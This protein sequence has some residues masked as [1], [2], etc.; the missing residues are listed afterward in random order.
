M[1]AAHVYA[2]IYEGLALRGAGSRRYVAVHAAED[3]SEG[4]D[5]RANWKERHGEKERGIKWKKSRNQFAFRMH[6]AWK[7]RRKKQ[8]TQAKLR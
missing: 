3:V 2:D 7:A 1:E 5:P 4:L 6:R 8:K